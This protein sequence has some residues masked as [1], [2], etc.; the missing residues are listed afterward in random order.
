MKIGS[1]GFCMP[2]SNGCTALRR[3]GVFK[4]SPNPSGVPCPG[5]VLL[6]VLPEAPRD[7]RLFQLWSKTLFSSFATFLWRVA[8]RRRWR[9]TRLAL[10]SVL[11]N[12]GN[13][14]VKGGINRVTLALAEHLQ[15]HGGEIRTNPVTLSTRRSFLPAHQ[16]E[17]KTAV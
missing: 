9:R 16:N 8:G 13:N 2:V 5:E 1:S 4:K 15:A 10:A 17:G 12:V 11:Q 3:E 6:W 7:A 14:L